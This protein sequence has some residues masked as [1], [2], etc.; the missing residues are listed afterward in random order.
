MSLEKNILNFAW[1]IATGNILILDFVLGQKFYTAYQ[2][3]ENLTDWIMFGALGLT[4]TLF[5]V[6]YWEKEINNYIRK[7]RMKK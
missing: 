5:C 1:T 2:S 4:A 6:A 3:K 7:K